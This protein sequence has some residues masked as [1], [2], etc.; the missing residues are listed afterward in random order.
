MPKSIAGLG[1][2]T[3]LVA[4]IL[5]LLT[6]A[7]PVLAESLPVDASLPAKQTSEQISGQASDLSPPEIAAALPAPGGLLPALTKA[8]KAKAEAQAA[9]SAALKVLSW[10]P[11]PVEIPV[12]A[13]DRPLGKEAQAAVEALQKLTGKPAD[14]TVIEAPVRD[15]EALIVLGADGTPRRVIAANPA[16]LAT[17]PG[18][19]ERQDWE[20]LTVMFRAI[21]HHL[22]G[23]PLGEGASHAA[24]ELEA[25]KYAGYL[26]QKSGADFDA[27]ADAVAPNLAEKGDEAFP[28][29]RV[30]LA[31]MASGWLTACTEAGACESHPHSH[32]TRSETAHPV[33]RPA[34]LDAAQEL[35]ALKTEVAALRHQPGEPAQDS[36]TD[37][38]AIPLKFDHY[39]R[40]P[41]GLVNEKEVASLERDAYSYA[42]KPGVEILTIVAEDLEGM[43]ARDYAR[44]VLR[45]E[46]VGRLD[47]GNGAVVVIA[48]V[49]GEW[50]IALAPGLASLM[51]SAEQQDKLEDR[52][53][54]FVQGIQKGS[55]PKVPTIAMGLTESAHAIMREP[56]IANAD[57]TIRYPDFAALRQAREIKPAK[58]GYDPAKDPVLGKIAQI[59]GRLIGPAGAS[60][61]V[62]LDEAALYGQP[63]LLQT[64]DG[65]QLV[66]YASRDL[67]DLMPLGFRP[68]RDYEVVARVIRNEDTTPRLALLS[69]DDVTPLP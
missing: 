61:G 11:D 16:F 68:G 15:A 8:A 6:F 44:A 5:S 12:S 47:I 56:A 37:V 14:Y 17:L 51:N 35:A 53:A 22:S 33:P 67:R 34:Q 42:Q 63:M 26:I 21:G 31:A 18:A 49:A 39:V 1:S 55:D 27:F 30:R 69:Y 20:S 38:A 65:A 59:R 60:G 64:E 3:S 52:A 29:R 66:I 4:L 28:A 57:W 19:A 9:E 23:H 24:L 58:D 13:L 40:D 10:R 7:N 2:S 32:L 43:K 62:K 25:D 41:A 36:G 54:A 46:R 45:Q 50:G 48:P